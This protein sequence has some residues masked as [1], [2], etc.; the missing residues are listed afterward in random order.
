MTGVSGDG[1]NHLANN[2]SKE[3]KAAA[4]MKPGQNRNRGKQQPR[5]TKTGEKVD[6]GEKKA[7]NP[8]NKGAFKPDISTRRPEILHLS[9][10]HI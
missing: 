10:I 5:G 9:L 4:G 7:T 8:G 3:E 1:L 6:G 2:A